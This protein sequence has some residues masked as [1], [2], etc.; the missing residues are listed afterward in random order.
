MKKTGLFKAAGAALLM[1]AVIG[2]MSCNNGSKDDPVDPSDP[3]PEASYV[4]M[5]DTYQTYYLNIADAD[6]GGLEGFHFKNL[7]TDKKVGIVIDKI[8]A[9]DSMSEEGAV[10]VFNFDDPETGSKYWG[11]EAG[12]TAEGVWSS[13]E[14]DAAT[15]PADAPERYIT[16]FATSQFSEHLYVGIVAKNFSSELKGDDISLIPIIGDPDTSKTIT[17]RAFVTK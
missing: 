14:V 9:S 10:A 4:E 7:N 6:L 2:F 1:A 15:E 12:T 5:T 17:F 16:G 8:F 13:G 3:V 11:F